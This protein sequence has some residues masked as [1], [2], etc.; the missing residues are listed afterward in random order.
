MSS[1]L[2]VLENAFLDE[3][4]KIAAAKSVM[5]VSKSRVGIRPA[6]VSTL[7][8]KEKEGTL[9]K[10]GEGSVGNLSATAASDPPNMTGSPARYNRTSSEVPSREDGRENT[11]TI[12]PRSNT[13]LAPAATNYPGEQGNT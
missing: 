2:D 1:P 3:L 5:K 10:M 12:M 7:L 4:H 6:R 11:V 8:R 9:W 13:L